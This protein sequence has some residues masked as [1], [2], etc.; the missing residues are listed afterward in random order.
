ME[1]PGEASPGR[2]TLVGNVAAGTAEAFDVDGGLSEQGNQLG[3]VYT[4]LRRFYAY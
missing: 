1:H 3:P 4:L 2:Q